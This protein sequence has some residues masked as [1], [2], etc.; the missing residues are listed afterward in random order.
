MKRILLQ[1]TLLLFVLQQ[2]FSQVIT[3]DSFFPNGDKEIT[4][5]FDL[6]QAKDVRVAG[7]LGKTSDVFLWSGAGTA[8]NAFEFQPTG[9]TNFGVPFEMGR[10]TSLGNDRWSIKLKPR[11]YYKVPVGRTIKKLGLLLKSGDGKAQTEDF[12]LDLYDDKLY[13]K[14]IEPDLNTF[15]K[16]ISH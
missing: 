14:L 1:C 4:L 11:D 3:T 16:K 12:I 13:Y 2:S 8:D 9:Q 5:I 7:L 6:K 10:M 15:L